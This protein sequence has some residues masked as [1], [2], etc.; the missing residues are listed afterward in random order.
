M[1]IKHRYKA[2]RLLAVLTVIANLKN[3]AAMSFK[4]VVAL[5]LL[6]GWTTAQA[7]TISFTTGWNTIRSINSGANVDNRTDFL[8]DSSNRPISQ[9][10][11][12]LGIL[13]GINI[14]F[15]GMSLSSRASANFRDDTL[16][17]T[18]GGLQRLQSMSLGITMPNYSFSRFASTRTSTCSDTGG[19]FSGSSCNTNLSSRTNGLFSAST[20]LGSLSAYIGPGF[21]NIGVRQNA[22][23]FT[24]ETD[25]DNGYVNF[26]SGQVRTAG[27]VRVTYDYSVVPVPAA[28][29]LFGSGLI[30]LIGVA[31]RTNRGQ[32]TV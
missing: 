10:D 12:S 15:F 7:A 18:V 31:R 19:L 26:R 22:T 16:F 20:S 14:D 6:S 23:L 17:S 4:L 8:S 9:F 1:N 5:L 2:L 29:W 13:T 24:N 30:G 28:A 27:S 25:G 11:P 3:S 32:T 21:V